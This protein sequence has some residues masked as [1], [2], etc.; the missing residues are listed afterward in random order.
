MNCDGNVNVLDTLQA[1]RFGGSLPVSQNSGCPPIGSEFNS[2][3]GDM[4]CDEDVD[5]VDA[6]WILRYVAAMPGNLPPGC[7]AIGSNEVS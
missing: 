3:F 2:I 6:L 4:D 5:A 1:L 7:A